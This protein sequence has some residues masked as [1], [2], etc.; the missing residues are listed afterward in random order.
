MEDVTAAKRELDTYLAAFNELLR[1]DVAAFNKLALEK[2]ANTLFAGGPIELKPGAACRRDSKSSV[3]SLPSSG[4]ARVQRPA[5]SWVGGHPSQALVTP[6]TD[7]CAPFERTSVQWW[8]CVA[9]VSD[10]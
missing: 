2:G 10:P 4:A 5:P 1:T 6:V 7:P 3:V 9:R 8:Q